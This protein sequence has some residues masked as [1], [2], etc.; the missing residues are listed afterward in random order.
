MVLNTAS[1]TRSVVGLTVPPRSDGN[2]RP[3]NLPEMILMSR[4][5]FYTLFAMIIQEKPIS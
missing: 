3:L 4:I 1:R 5:Y 2:R